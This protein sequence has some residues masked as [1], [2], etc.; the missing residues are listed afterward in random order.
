MATRSDR[1]A[2]IESQL[3]NSRTRQSQLLG[4]LGNADSDGD[5]KQ[6]VLSKAAPNLEMPLIPMSLTASPSEVSL[7]PTE[8]RVNDN[9]AKIETLERSAGKFRLNTCFGMSDTL[10][11]L[12]RVTVP[13]LTCACSHHR[14]N[15][16]L[17]EQNALLRKYSTIDNVKVEMQTG[18]RLWARLRGAVRGGL[19]MSP[20]KRKAATAEG[21]VE[22]FYAVLGALLQIAADV[23]PVLAVVAWQH[24]PALLAVM[25]N[26][27][28]GALM[29]WVMMMNCVSELLRDSVD[30][31]S[32][33]CRGYDLSASDQ[34]VMCHWAAASLHACM[35]LQD[36]TVT[37]SV[38]PAQVCVGVCVRVCV[39]LCVC[40][41]MYG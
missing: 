18:R 17:V 14:R 5:D 10:W 23:L 29:A 26:A 6:Q 16:L 7:T 9:S 22:A 38:M 20:K 1:I 11:R 32:G 27:F 8:T 13:A 39:C 19:G 33:L 40:M 41:C 30:G 3:A 2:A 28:F 24:G 21:P 25:C 35:R 31:V 4:S 37:V 15:G 12:E 34:L 36:C